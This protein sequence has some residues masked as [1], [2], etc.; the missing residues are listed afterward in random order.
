MESVSMLGQ[1]LG[2]YTILEKLGEGGMGV[3]YKARDTR[4]GRL[5]AL[6]VL[7]GE[8]VAGAA[9]RFAQEARA[10]SALNHPNI[11]TIY[12]IASEGGREFIVMEY[13]GGRTLD[14]LIG[15]NGLPAAEALKY[16]VEMADALAS[17]HGAG[18]I[19]RDLKPTNFML[20]ERGTIKVLDFGL[21]KLTQEAAWTQSTQ[22]LRAETQEGTILGTVS[23][24]SPE[25]AEGRKVDARSDIFAFG[26]VLYEMLTG[27]RAFQKQSQIATLVAVLREDPPAM[28]AV[29]PET[30]AGVEKVVER[31]LRKDPER[32]YQQASEVKLVIE[33]L[34][35]ECWP[36]ARPAVAAEVPS[37]IPA[38]AVLPFIDLSPGKDQEYFCDGIAEEIL[39]ELAKLEGLRVAAR[40]SAFR[41]K[42]K[43][44]DIT[45]I[46]RQLKVSAVLEGSV[47]KAGDRLR[48]T[49]QLINV[50][51]GYHL[52][53]ERY[54][55]RMEDIFAIQDEISQAIVESLKVKLRPE[56]VKRYTP[57][58]PA[59]SHYLKGRHC[60]N[61][62]S[63]EA[64]R[65]GV[66]HFQQAIAED[67]C[68]A[69][70]YAGLADCYVMLGMQGFV[71]PR[72]SMP[73]AKAAAQKALEIDAS[74]AE[75][76]ASLGSARAVYDWDWSGAG[77]E[78]ERALA[79]NPGYATAL[80]WYALFY[81]ATNGQ[82]EGAEREIRKAQDLDPLSLPIAT[83]LAVILIF[84]RRFEDAIAQLASVR[85][86]DPSFYR[87]PWYLG[88]AYAG[89][90]KWEEALRALLEA[91]AL[92]P[93]EGRVEGALGHAY[94]RAGER[95][96]ACEI[97]D[98]LM[99]S[100]GRKYVEPASVAVVYAG[101]EERDRAFEWLG[102]ALEQRSGYHIWLKVDPI[103]DPVRG[104][105]RLAAC[106]EKMGV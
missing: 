98:Q 44:E 10:A 12:D 48:I 6:K 51:D 55:R 17:A 76:H 38:I 92:S 32:R 16:A 58:L 86:L 59:Y 72:E 31:C 21:A 102:K 47:R 80:H 8:K 104:D 78:F 100:S 73:R 7:R 74:V 94:A 14:Q 67:P 81:L 40:T 33:E 93:G 64:L 18:I 13:L 63:E 79:L 60:W 39:N 28:R 103:W 57:K 9:E 83:D 56:T 69:P 68:Y 2:H 88:R 27:R 62:R 1:R 97:I 4:L 23:Y 29:A 82:L 5:V 95:A 34:L 75:A 49:A 99:A 96:K 26:A 54:D 19:H 42:G 53:S 70:G 65:H 106:L 24:M 25:Q 105:G 20:T 90:G 41:F 45:E 43:A 91:G 36:G 37:K 52:W 22:T 85:E 71:A 87:V 46:G 84:Q 35:A 11:I 89:L 77:K 101:L 61:K 30:P 66:E 50:A 15:G 3:V